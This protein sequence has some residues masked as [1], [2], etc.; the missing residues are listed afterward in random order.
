MFSKGTEQGLHQDT[1]VFHVFPRN[2]MMGIWIACEDI[3]LESG[4]LEYYPGSH[5]APFFPEFTN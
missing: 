5:R 1:C 3:K 2:F 4:P